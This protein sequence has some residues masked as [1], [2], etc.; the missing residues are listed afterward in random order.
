MNNYQTQLMLVWQTSCISSNINLIMNAA[1]CHWSKIIVGHAIIQ[2]DRVIISPQPIYAGPHRKSVW[3]LFKNVSLIP[4]CPFHPCR[5]YWTQV[6]LDMV[7]CK[8]KSIFAPSKTTQGTVAFKELWEP[9][10]HSEM[11]R[12]IECCSLYICILRLGHVL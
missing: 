4:G 7:S 9:P 8:V 12:S 6:L 11:D 3:V 10:W 2:W 1:Y 5:W